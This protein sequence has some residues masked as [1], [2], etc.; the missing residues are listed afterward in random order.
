M[1]AAAKE[2]VTQ[3]GQRVV[4]GAAEGLFAPDA[5]IHLAH[6]FESMD[7]PEFE[8]RALDAL[9]SAFPDLERRDFIRMVGADASGATWVGVG[10][11]WVGTF[12]APFLDIPVTGRAASIRYHDFLRVEGDRIVEMQALWDFPERLH[13][14]DA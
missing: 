1:T 2:L 12:A 13:L 10:G 9:R 14:Q 3:W 8:S 11:H 6:P 4:D 7:V 5:A